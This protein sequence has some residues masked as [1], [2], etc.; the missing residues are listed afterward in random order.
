MRDAVM[1]AVFFL[2]SLYV[3]SKCSNTTLFAE[4]SQLTAHK[5]L[6]YSFLHKSGQ[7]T[8]VVE[9]TNQRNIPASSYEFCYGVWA[10]QIFLFIDMSAQSNLFVYLHIHSRYWLCP[11]CG[12]RH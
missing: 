8:G 1:F 7:L 5:S 9:R 10:T 11:Q 2:C 3:S 4:P 6:Y 12:G